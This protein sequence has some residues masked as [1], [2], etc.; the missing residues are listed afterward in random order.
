MG[1]WKPRLF[2]ESA[3][4][5]IGAMQGDSLF[6]SPCAEERLGFV[7]STHTLRI[8]AGSLWAA[9]VFKGNTPASLIFF[10]LF[11]FPSPLR[12]LPGNRRRR[13]RFS[14]WV[15]AKPLWKRLGGKE[16][17]SHLP[18]CLFLSF[19]HLNVTVCLWNIC[20]QGIS[21]FFPLVAVLLLFSYAAPTVILRQ[22]YL[23][24]ELK[25]RLLSL[26]T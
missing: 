15:N 18:V 24:A 6:S 14:K 3:N 12:R 22:Q 1:A 17:I 16:K 20:F 7:S 9:C 26:M 25:T 2:S 10:Y 11:P 8:G 4:R 21:V 23:R 19:F 5:S 13:G